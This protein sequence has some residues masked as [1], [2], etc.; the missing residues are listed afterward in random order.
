MR[1][2]V[3]VV[4]VTI[5]YHPKYQDNGSF[6]NYKIKLFILVNFN[7]LLKHENKK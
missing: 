5:F 7:S 1:T 2:A 6:K 4:S 3:T